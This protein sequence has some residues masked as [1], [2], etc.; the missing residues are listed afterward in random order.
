[1][2]RVTSGG[3]GSVVPSFIESESADI[4]AIPPTASNGTTAVQLVALAVGET[5]YPLTLV[6]YN[7]SGV[8]RTV[9]VQD[10][11]GPTLL[12][13]FR[14]GPDQSAIFDLR[15]DIR[16]GSGEALQFLLDAGTTGVTCSGAVFQR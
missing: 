7:D 9:T 12:L 10:S 16:T 5:I 15:G 6:F 14:L 4:V 13:R 1:M 3:G 2:L 11:T 8:A